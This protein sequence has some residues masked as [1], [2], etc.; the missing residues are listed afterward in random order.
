MP[1]AEPSEPKPGQTL[2]VAGVAVNYHASI[3]AGAA[4]TAV[5]IHGFGATLDCWNDVYRSLAEAHSVVRLD[6][7][8]AG[9]SS[10]PANASYSP[11]AQAELLRAFIESLG[12]RKVVLIGHSL[13]GAI[14]LIACRQSMDARAGAGIAGL[15]LLNAAVYSRRVPFFIAA[16]RNPVKNGTRRE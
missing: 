16:L 3:R 4:P 8:G 12:L 13:G 10:K 14:A 1:R 2:E 15:V 5:M 6:L 9:F 11:V 7:M